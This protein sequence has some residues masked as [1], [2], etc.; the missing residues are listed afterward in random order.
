MQMEGGKS[1]IFAMDTDDFSPILSLYDPNGRHLRENTDT[2]AQ[3]VHVCT[4]TGAYRLH[5]I[6]EIR[7]QT[8]KYKLSIQRQP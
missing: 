5:A 2:P 4:M 1:Y 8:G 3:L 7:G 6:S